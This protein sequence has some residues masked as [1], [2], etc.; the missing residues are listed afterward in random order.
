M[1]WIDLFHPSINFLWFAGAAIVKCSENIY[2]LVYHPKA[3]RIS[4]PGPYLIMQ[5]FCLSR[6]VHDC[7]LCLFNGQNKTRILIGREG[8]V[9]KTRTHDLND[10]M[11]SN[12]ARKSSLQSFL[13]LCAIT[14]IK[15]MYKTN[16]FH[17][18]SVCTLI[19][20]TDAVITRWGHQRHSPTAR[21]ALLCLYLVL[22]SSVRYHARVHTQG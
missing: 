19:T 21:S 7:V 20:G 22:T 16:R 10:V 11:S 14:D 17:L 9:I 15:T 3:S 12:C 13:I 18:A 1:I 5:K 8:F 2:S 4:R 6:S